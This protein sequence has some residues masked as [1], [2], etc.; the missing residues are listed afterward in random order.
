[1]KLDGRKTLLLVA[2]VFVLPVV[3]SYVT[4]YFLRPQSRMN[5]G[6]L[7]S[8]QPLP[9]LALQDAAGRPFSLVELKGK[10]IMIHVAPA[11]CDQRCRDMLLL[12]RQVRTAQGKDMDRVER[13]WIV[14]DARVP[15]AELLRD[16]GSMR[17]ALAREPAA[18]SVFPTEADRRAH[19]YLVDPLGNLMLRFPANPDPKRV[20]KDL[21]RLLKYSRIG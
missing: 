8:P 19:V 4:Y 18:A 17:I 15:D 3:A 12:M 10:W 20:I 14:E 21:E 7:L 13:L 2:A 16:Y 6:E 9:P 11:E 1:M 5:Y